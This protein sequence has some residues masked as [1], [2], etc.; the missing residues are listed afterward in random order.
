MELIYSLAALVGTSI[1]IIKLVP[2]AVSTWGFRHSREAMIGLSQATQW[3]LLVNA[4]L[5]VVL[6][7]HFSSVPVAL[8]SA[9]YAPIAVMSLWFQTRDSRW[10]FWVGTSLVALCAFGTIAS[11]MPRGIVSLAE[12]VAPVLAFAL[13]LPQ[14]VSTWR[15][16]HD[17]DRLRAISLWTQALILVNATAWGLVAVDLGVFA[18]GAPGIVNGP[19]AILTIALVRRARS[20]GSAP[21]PCSSTESEAERPSAPRATLPAH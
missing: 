7:V 9:I 17:G 19:L 15:N 21:T 18:V 6:G 16:R 10:H 1:A 3:L 5:W 13:F 8:P 11:G 2:Q 4:G 20:R 12:V 14:A